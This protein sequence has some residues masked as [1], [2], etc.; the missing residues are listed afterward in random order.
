MKERLVIDGTVMI[1]YTPLTFKKLGNFFRMVVS[2]VP[3][4][5]N[6]DMDYV[7]KEIERVGADIPYNH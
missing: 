6:V 4:P 2:C 7:V 1:G 3:S 5:T